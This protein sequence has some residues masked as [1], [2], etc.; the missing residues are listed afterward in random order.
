MKIQSPFHLVLHQCRAPM[1][2]SSARQ[3]RT[4]FC[5]TFP[6]HGRRQRSREQLSPCV[7]VTLV[8]PRRLIKRHFCKTAQISV[9][10]FASPNIKMEKNLRLS[11]NVQKLISVSASEGFAPG[12]RNVFLMHKDSNWKRSK[13]APPTHKKLPHAVAPS[14]P[15]SFRFPAPPK[16]I[17]DLSAT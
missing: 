1:R 9:I 14:L 6:S 8:A 16:D 15:P 10:F 12:P 2:Y 17:N 11:L 13:F 3:L 7:L 4:I 5:L